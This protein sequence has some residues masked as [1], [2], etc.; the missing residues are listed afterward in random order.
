MFSNETVWLEKVALLQSEE[1]AG[2]SAVGS[3][4]YQRLVLSW[5]FS[6]SPTVNAFQTSL[7]P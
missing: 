4:W 7:S 3:L 5:S 6:I 2:H 1:M